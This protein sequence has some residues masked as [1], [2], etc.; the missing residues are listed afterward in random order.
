MSEDRVIANTLE[1]AT[2]TDF[3]VAQAMQARRLGDFVAAAYADNVVPVPFQNGVGLSDNNYFP[4]PVVTGLNVYASSS[5]S[6]I[7]VSPGSLTQYSPPWA[8]FSGPAWSG[9][10]VPPSDIQTGFL[11]SMTTVPY[12]STAGLGLSN[13]AQEAY[14]LLVA[15][16]VEVV[17]LTSTVS[18]FDV[19]TQAFVPTTLTKRIEL[20]IQF[21]WI[22]GAALNADQT[23]IPSLD[24]GGPEWEPIAYVAFVSPG[25][26][27]S[28]SGAN[29]GKVIDVARRVSGRSGSFLGS[30]GSGQNSIVSMPTALFGKLTSARSP[31]YGG[32]PS[33]ALMGSA[34]ADIDGERAFLS[35]SQDHRQVA[36]VDAVDGSN[37]TDWTLVHYYLCPLQSPTRRRWPMRTV[38]N[39]SADVDRSLQS[40]GIIVGSIIQP[41][42]KRTN[43][44]PI[45]L[46]AS[47][48]TRGKWGAQSTV[49]AGAAQYIG[50]GHS[51]SNGGFNAIY[52][53]VRSAGGSVLY[54]LGEQNNIVSNQ[55]IRWLCPYVDSIEGDSLVSGYVVRSTDIDLRDIV[56]RTATAVHLL[57]EM[58]DGTNFTHWTVEVRNR[59][60]NPVNAITPYRVSP[61]TTTGQRLAAGV[62]V[63]GN[64][65]SHEWDH[66]MCILRVPTGW[67]PANSH[68]DASSLSAEGYHFWLHAVISSWESTG[69]FFGEVQIRVVGWDE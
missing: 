68:G 53:M 28:E 19:A 54:P 7:Y 61:A 8:P 5:S 24:A 30:G 15:R 20:R 26:V 22:L 33:S 39:V 47:G 58:L 11:R 50:S 16:L 10:R 13:S 31:D 9:T 14:H 29:Q 21:Q 65:G 17:S 37:P 49:P 52:P 45:T 12:V 41:T 18:I 36:D 43:S 32:A 27:N 69:T 23:I 1:R 42:R 56:P 3:N 57:F 25:G 6:E 34:V 64:P 60:D 66:P 59:V 4:R 55:K 44:L 40:R 35:I 67:V 48:T 46:Y 38:L 63:S 62:M 51:Y 2:S